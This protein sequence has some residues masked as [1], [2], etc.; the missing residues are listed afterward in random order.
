MTATTEAPTEATAGHPLTPPSGGIGFGATMRV[1]GALLSRDIVVTGRE[2]P[3]FLVK[4]LVQPFLMLFIFGKVLPD[5]G[6]IDGNFAQLL[7][8][9]VI[10]LNAFLGGLQATAMPMILDFSFTREIED[11]LLAPVSMAVVA[12]EKVIFGALR[13]LLSGVVM[14]PIGFLILEGVHW[15]TSGLLP[16]FGLLVLCSLAAAAM[17][18][19]MGTFVPPNRIDLVFTAVLTPLMFTGATQFPWSGLSNLPWFQVVCALNPLTYASEG[20]RNVLLG[21]E[22]PSMDLWITLVALTGMTVAMLVAGVIGFK[23]RAVD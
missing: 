6:F 3:S 15:Q 9:G 19:V 13:G 11:R 22:V 2:V 14:I 1:F 16:A 21:S 7:F 10:A 8:P 12:A 18:M 4:T 5:L 20:L 17:G 23:R